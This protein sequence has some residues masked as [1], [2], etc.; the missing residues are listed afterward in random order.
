MRSEAVAGRAGGGP[1]DG[2]DGAPGILGADVAGDAVCALGG[3]GGGEGLASSVDAC[4][5]V[6]HIASK[7]IREVATYVFVH[8][9]P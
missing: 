1:G 7:P 8:P 5:R 9:A 4:V 3:G 2:I 6:R